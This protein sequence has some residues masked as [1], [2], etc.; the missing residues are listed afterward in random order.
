MESKS[1][2]APGK[3]TSQLSSKSSKKS[4]KA[5]HRSGGSK[6]YSGFSRANLSQ[7]STRR[8]GGS[9]LET[10]GNAPLVVMLDGVDVTPKSLLTLAPSAA[11]NVQGAAKLHSGQETPTSDSGTEFDRITSS[12]SKSALVSEGSVDSTSE[13]G[14]SEQMESSDGEFIPIPQMVDHSAQQDTDKEEDHMLTEEQLE[15]SVTLVLRETET[16]TMLHIAGLCIAQDSASHP[17]VTEKNKRYE[18]FLAARVGSDSFVPRHA[19]TFNNAHKSK[20]VMAAPAPTRDMGVNATQWDIYDTFDADPI[21][22]HEEI[23]A[24]CKKEVDQVVADSLKSPGC[25]LNVDV[26]GGGHPSTTAS[27]RS[28]KESGRDGS[29]SN[30]AN[31]SRMNTSK[32]VFNHESS[33]SLTESRRSSNLVASGG[34]SQN[35]IGSNPSASIGQVSADVDEEKPQEAPLNPRILPMLRT[36]ERMVTQNVYHSE[37][38]QYRDYPTGAE[39]V[40]AELEHNNRDTYDEVAEV[41]E[42]PSLVELFQFK[43]DLTQ[44]R[45]V[46]CADWNKVNQDLLAVSYGEFDY[47]A[48]KEGL[49]LFWSLKNPTYPERVIRTHSGVTALHFS[50]VHPNLLAAGFYDGVVAIYDVRKPDNKPVLDNAQLAGKHSDTVWEV[51][52]VDRGSEKGEALVSIST[53]GRVVEWSMKKG[54]EHTDLMTMKRVANPAHNNADGRGEGIIFR[55]ASGLCFDFPKND[56]SVYLAGTEDGV[57]HRCSISYN[58]QYLDSYFGHTGPVYKIR[59]NPFWSNA[60]LSSSADWSVRLWNMKEDNVVMAC[61]SVDLT[62][63]VNDVV[64]SPKLSTMFGSVCDDGRIEIWDIAQN[65]LD[66]IIV[67]GA[68]RKSEPLGTKRTVLRFS[69]NSPVV[70]TGNNNGSVDVFRMKGVAEEVLTQEEQVKRLQEAM[71]PNDN[72]GKSE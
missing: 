19:Q 28:F 26:I 46:S 66:P 62:D 67:H 48:Q 7:R 61:Q 11:A 29:N 5:S 40:E 50:T 21:A 59:C 42:A 41:S 24:V 20:E 53:D 57:I 52:W 23:Q 4:T 63:Q 38:I 3:S 35:M 43:C 54:L 34:H 65:P 72:S 69:H 32:S 10:G 16:V 49:I 22:P 47:S 44:G 37:H 33:K 31:N 1:S 60:F 8:H 39:A 17:V 68:R 56:S 6:L 51:Q 13:S 2:I 9:T 70:I 15:E 30:S 25:L 14:D 71:Y 27:V 36:L 58:E 55:Q 12:F 64:W 45:N 18:E